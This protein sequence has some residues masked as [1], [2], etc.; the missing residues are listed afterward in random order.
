MN[1]P[2]L[3]QI[4]GLLLI[5]AAVSASLIFGNRN[6]EL[7]NVNTFIQSG[8]LS[9]EGI[10]SPVTAVGY[11][12]LADMILGQYSDGFLR[13]WD[14]KSGEVVSEFFLGVTEK[15]PIVFSE[16][17]DYIIAPLEI[18]N[19]EFWGSGSPVN[20]IG[21]VYGWDTMTGEIIDCYV[22]PCQENLIDNVVYSD[23]GFVLVHSKDQLIVYYSG[24][25]SIDY[26]GQENKGTLVFLQDSLESWI[27]DIAIGKEG[28]RFAYALYDGRI[29]ITHNNT[30]WP[31]RIFLDYFI[32]IEEIQ[33]N[34]FFAER[35]EFS[36]DG[37][38]L[39]LIYDSQLFVWELGFRN[40][41][42]II[43]TRLDEEANFVFD[44][45]SD[46]LFLGEGNKLTIWDMD[47]KDMLR[48]IETDY[49]ITCFRIVA[50]Q[51]M[52]LVG[53]SMGAIHIWEWSTR[54]D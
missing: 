44:S 2:I 9:R 33:R 17:G 35:L 4:L 45:N 51:E 7:F 1:K 18:R 30:I 32:Q 16:E 10:S 43:Y 54:S 26:L 11:Y 41:N 14:L 37:K 24:G 28:D 53:D 20:Y 48:E 3:W 19:E 22:Q 40:A 25:Y 46:L 50:D 21:A 49:E 52:L 8:T 12:D 36:P 27:D 29:W 39:A 47:R 6:K 42:Q 5:V 13:Q 31:L 34:G 38:Y 23:F 15:Y